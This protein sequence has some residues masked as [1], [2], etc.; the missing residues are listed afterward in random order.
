M[1]RRGWSF[2]AVAA[3]LVAALAG[4]GGDAGH[5]DPAK[6]PNLIPAGDTGA[7]ALGQPFDSAEDVAEWV[8]WVTEECED[9]VSADM[10]Q[11]AEY[12]G[13]V[14]FPLYEPYVAEWVTCA[15]Q[16]YDKF[17]VVMFKPGQMQA[18]QAAWREHMRAGRIS[19]N[20][21]WAFGNGF[22]VTAGPLG[23][24]RLGLHF[25]W[26]TPVEGVPNAHV[27]K[28]DVEGCQFVLIGGHHH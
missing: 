18:F 11:L 12:L 19:D 25:L 14:R 27:I 13:P 7:A 28:S 16:P 9:P 21:D 17:G 22:G 6:D 23:M 2:P 24:E 3:V 10:G 15:V 20:P 26:C 5:H 8:G 1:R 4:C